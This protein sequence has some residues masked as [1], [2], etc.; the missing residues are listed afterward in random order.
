M[1]TK[2][3]VI[4]AVCF[5]LAGM[6]SFGSD[7]GNNN[8]R[9]GWR[10]DFGGGHSTRAVELDERWV[11]Y[12]YNFG[13]TPPVMLYYI[14]DEFNGEETLDT[15]FVKFSYGW[16]DRYAFYLKAGMARLQSTFFDVQELVRWDYGDGTWEEYNYGGGRVHPD[17]GE[18]EWDLFYGGGFK[19]VF[20]DA[21]GFKVG[22]DAQYNTYSLDNEV[23]FWNWHYTDE[24]GRY[25]DRHI[26]DETETTEYHL[27]VIFSKQNTMVHPYGGIKLSAYESEYEGRAW[28]YDDFSTP[29]DQEIQYWDFT[30]EATDMWGFFLGADFAL[31]EMF[32]VNGEIRV[33]DEAAMTA[34][35]SWKF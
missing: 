28:Y 30:M 10:I 16:G 34:M 21:G 6:L 14:V 29:V 8:E 25:F 1:K 7:V 32:T 18:G 23:M 13:G 3:V 20:Y 27:A 11:T 9:T 2:W 15:N 31:T 12:Q 4:F 5:L 22:V 17:M 35:L 26:L 24:T 33:G 19:A